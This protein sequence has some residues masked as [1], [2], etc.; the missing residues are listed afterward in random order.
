MQKYGKYKATIIPTFYI[1]LQKWQA[2]IFENKIL[3]SFVTQLISW[4]Y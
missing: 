4:V 1:Y 3:N 2:T